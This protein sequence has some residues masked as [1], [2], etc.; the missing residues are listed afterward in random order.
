MS[1][2]LDRL[3]RAYRDYYDVRTGDGVLPPFAAEA[4]FRSHEEQYF[5]VR[6]ARI[7]EAEANEYLFFAVEDHL[8]ADRLRDLADAAWREGSA[9]IVPHKDHRSSDVGLIVLAGSAAPG[10]LRAAR[11]IRRY[12]SWRWGLWGW[13]HLL[14]CAADLSEGT[15]ASNWQGRRLLPHVR[16]AIAP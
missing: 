5:L 14:L 10:T 15:C 2:V 6:A 13:S 3:L 4:V 7:S 12:Q 8:D 9:R 1:P 11:Q 16:R